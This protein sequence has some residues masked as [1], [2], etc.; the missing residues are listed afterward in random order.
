MES[1][2]GQRCVNGCTQEQSVGVDAVVG[3]NLA[4]LASLGAHNIEQKQI[5]SCNVSN[6]VNSHPAIR[7]TFG[8]S[9]DM[10]KSERLGDRVSV[11][12]CTALAVSML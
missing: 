7:R 8:S 3:H 10:T 4:L 9:N 11:T 5:P 6:E 2:N 12:Q 1:T